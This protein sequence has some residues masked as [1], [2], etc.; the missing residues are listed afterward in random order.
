MTFKKK[1][2]LDLQNEFYKMDFLIHDLKNKVLK[3]KFNFN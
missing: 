3:D 1:V 2:D